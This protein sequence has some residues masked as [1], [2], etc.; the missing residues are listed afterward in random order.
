MPTKLFFILMILFWE[1]LISLFVG[2]VQDEIAVKPC[3]FGICCFWNKLL[4]LKEG[5]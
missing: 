4:T 2:V 5:R 3:L 1:T